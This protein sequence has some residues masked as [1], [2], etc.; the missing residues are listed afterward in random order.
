MSKPYTQRRHGEAEYNRFTV[1]PS[2]DVPSGASRTDPG[3]TD[4]FAQLVWV[5]NSLST[6]GGGSGSTS[7]GGVTIKDAAGSV[8]ATVADLSGTAVSGANALATLIVDADGNQIT[9][10]GSVISAEAA[11]SGTAGTTILQMGGIA[12]TATPSAVSD[13]Q[14]VA[15]WMD[16]YGRPVIYGA[17]LSLNAIDVNNISDPIISRLGPITNMSAVTSATTGT[18]I[19]ISNYHNFTVH[20]ETSA[21]SA[22]SV[23]AIQSSL[24][25]TNWATIVSDTISSD[26]VTEY[27]GSNVAYVYLR[28]LISSYTDGGFTSK[29]Y[30]G[31]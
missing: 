2:G 26:G 6:S 18:A 29:L 10:F 23:F 3:G 30:A 17:N 27:S 14:A 19:D 11:P 24:D 8:S 12:E 13:G 21:T 16:E 31:N 1:I 20:V 28:T 4:H 22:G 25:G 5:V 15:M 9:T 7:V